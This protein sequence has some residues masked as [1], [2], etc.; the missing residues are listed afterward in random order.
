MGFVTPRLS[1]ATTWNKNVPLMIVHA[2]KDF[3]PHSNESLSLFLDKAINQNL[4][5]TLINYSNGV[6]GFDV[7]TDN[8]PTRQII[9]TTLEF[10][11]F[12]LKQ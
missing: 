8:E 6:H 2:G 11:E 5:V 12:Y 1:E 7:Y 4:P 10:W 3:V 9:K